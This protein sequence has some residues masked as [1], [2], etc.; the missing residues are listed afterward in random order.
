[1]CFLVGSLSYFCLECFNS[2]SRPLLWWLFSSV[3]R[4]LI[5]LQATR[6]R[7][8]WVNNTEE[9]WLYTEGGWFSGIAQV[10]TQASKEVIVCTHTHT[11]TCH[12]YYY[13]YYCRDLLPKMLPFCFTLRPNPAFSGA[14]LRQEFL[15]YNII[16]VFPAEVMRNLQS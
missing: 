13:Y 8:P 11:H 16:M 10:I 6:L 12:Y 5:I 14:W 7:S 4:Y 3:S 15:F 1:M 9:S 2:I